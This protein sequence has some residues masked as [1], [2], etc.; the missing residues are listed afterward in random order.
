MRNESSKNEKKIEKRTISSYMPGLRTEL[1]SSNCSIPRELK[2]RESLLLK[3]TPSYDTNT[4]DKD[5]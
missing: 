1:D 5:Y 4:K 2:L 3:L